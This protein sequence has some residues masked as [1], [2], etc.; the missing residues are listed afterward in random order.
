MTRDCLGKQAVRH[1]ALETI[2]SM[3]FVTGLIVAAGLFAQGWAA[4][5]PGYHVVAAE[6]NGNT[7]TAQLRLSGKNCDVYG[8]DLPKLK[9]QVEYQ[10]SESNYTQRV[11]EFE[12]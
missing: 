8:E 10:T 4:D 6:D 11:A 2:S 3:R 1:C 7:L 9:L 12:C 5:C